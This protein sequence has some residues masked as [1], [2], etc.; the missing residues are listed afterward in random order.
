M[1]CSKCGNQLQDGV[2]FCP[3]C[4]NQINKTDTTYVEKEVKVMLDPSEVVK[5]SKAKKTTGQTGTYGFVLMIVS[6]V[7]SL[8][9]MFAVGS[10]LFIPITI[11]STTL[12]VV[13]V[14]MRMFFQ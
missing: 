10:E 12:F 1:F 5:N 13:G 3:K 14:L 8:F 4:G 7:F 11:F 9:A 6:I 2:Q